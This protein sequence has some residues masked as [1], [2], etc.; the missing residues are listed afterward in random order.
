MKELMEARASSSASTSSSNIE[1]PHDIVV[2]EGADIP[3]VDNLP[4]G[5]QVIHQQEGIFT[6]DGSFT[7]T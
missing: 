2:V 7:E 5:F 4:E 3:I 6:L 1:K